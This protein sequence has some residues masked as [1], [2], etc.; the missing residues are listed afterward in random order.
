M[1]KER[2]WLH[3][4]HSVQDELEEIIFAR[5]VA[6]M[7]PIEPSTGFVA[8]TVRAACQAHTHRRLVRRVALIAATLLINGVTDCCSR[9]VPGS[10]TT[11]LLR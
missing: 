4:E 10:T 7:P 8:R 1:P 5:L 3:A 6:E 9:S 11:W 2:Q